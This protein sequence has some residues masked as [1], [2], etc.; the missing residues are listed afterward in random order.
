MWVPVVWVNV[1]VSVPSVQERVCEGDRDRPVSVCVPR[2]V[3]VRLAEKV[4]VRLRDEEGLGEFVRVGMAVGVVVRVA[5]VAETVRVQLQDLDPVQLKVQ[6]T[7]GVAVGVGVAE[8]DGGDSVRPRVTDWRRVWVQV[9][10]VGVQLAEAVGGGVGEVESEAVRRREGEREKRRVW[11]TVG[12][13]DRVLWVHVWLW[14]RVRP[15]C[16]VAV[17]VPVDVQEALDPLGVADET[18]RL[19]VWQEGLR[20]QDRVGVQW[21]SVEVAEPVGLREGVEVPVGETEAV[22]DREACCDGDRVAET[23]GVQ[24]GGLDQEPERVPGDSEQVGV[25]DTE[26][27]PVQ[28]LVHCRVAEGLQVAV[29]VGVGVWNRRVAVLVTDEDGVMVLDKERDPVGGGGEPVSVMAAVPDR[30]GQREWEM[31]EGV[32]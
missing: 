16:G 9:E 32:G 20:V 10:R 8:P 19:G 2:S 23:D 26:P 31:V 14:V 12:A 17:G 28:V 11:L 21:A 3:S 29:L 24:E 13:T 6:V 4:R 27:L 1:R 30:V 22:W 7:R 5:A 15:G 18:D 25:R